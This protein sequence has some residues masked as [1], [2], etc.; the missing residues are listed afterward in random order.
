MNED[1]RRILEMLAQGKITADEADRLLDALYAPTMSERPLTVLNA[2]APV[3]AKNARFLRVLV[4]SGD[5][6][7]VNVRVPMQLL[8]AGIKLASIIP[9]EAQAKVDEALASKGMNMKVADLTPEMMDELIGG[10]AEFTV[11]IEDKDD[12]VRV[13]CE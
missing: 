7:R 5:G 12:K 6:E 3:S 1:R 8:R 2:P 4:E 10:L 9:P 11:D 13:F